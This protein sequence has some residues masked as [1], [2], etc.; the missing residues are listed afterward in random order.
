MKTQNTTKLTGKS[1]FV[2]AAVTLAGTAMAAPAFAHHN[3]GYNNSGYSSGYMKAPYKKDM[4]RRNDYRGR[5]QYL[6][7]AQRYPWLNRINRYGTRGKIIRWGYGYLNGCYRVKRTGRYNGSPAIVTLR[8][9]LDGYGQSVRQG[10]TKRLVRYID[11]Y[12]P[13]YRRSGGYRH[14]KPMYRY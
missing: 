1:L 7:P 5:G 14:N 9:C 8:Y 4:Y 10:G 13:M 11:A 3:S 2:L 6:T 12:G